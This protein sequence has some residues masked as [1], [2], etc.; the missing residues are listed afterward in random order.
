M[1]LKL[2]DQTSNACEPALTFDKA[3]SLT[4]TLTAPCVI[5]IHCVITMQHVRLICVT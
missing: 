2:P 5:S 4:T 3:S 1:A